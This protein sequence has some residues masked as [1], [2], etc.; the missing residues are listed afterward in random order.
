MRAV[1]LARATSDPASTSRPAT[2]GSRPASSHGLG[3][4]PA[5]ALLTSLRSASSILTG[6]VAEDSAAAAGTGGEGD[7]ANAH[8]A[9]DVAHKLS[10]AADDVREPSED[11]AA[12]TQ[13]HVHT[14][15][16]E[17]ISALV[18]AVAPSPAN[19]ATDDASVRLDGLLATLGSIR[20][21]LDTQLKQCGAAGEASEFTLPA[22]SAS[23]QLSDQDPVHDSDEAAE[24]TAEEEATEEEEAET[25]DHLM[26]C[27][28]AHIGSLF[29]AGSP[30]LR[31]M[32]IDRLA[33]HLQ[34]STTTVARGSTAG[35]PS[36]G[37]DEEDSRNA[38]HMAAEEAEA[39]AAA[40]ASAAGV[41][42]TS[43][44]GAP[45]EDLGSSPPRF[46]ARAAPLDP[47]EERPFGSSEDYWIS[48]GKG[49]PDRTL[50]TRE[51]AS[52][53]EQV[54]AC[55]LM[56]R[57]ALVDAEVRVVLSA[58]SLLDPD[59]PLLQRILPACGDGMAT[60]RALALLLAPLEHAMGMRSVRVSQGA[61]L[62]LYALV[63]HRAVEPKRLLPQLLRPLCIPSG[64][65]AINGGGVPALAGDAPASKA[66]LASSAKA[67]PPRLCCMR[68]QLV[69]RL[70]LGRAVLAGGPPLLQKALWPHSTRGLIP[71]ARALPLCADALRASD[72]EVRLA[73][74]ELLVHAHVLSPAE[75]EAWVQSQPNL[76]DDLHDE[77]EKQLQETSDKLRRARFHGN[78]EAR[79]LSRPG[80]SAG[81]GL[82]TLGNLMTRPDTAMGGCDAAVSLT[83]TLL[84][85]PSGDAPQIL[86]LE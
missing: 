6:R 60:R 81:T 79:S 83:R 21:S 9:V 28:P 74:V 43:P 69:Q 63:T 3:F 57:D 45:P 67:D 13:Q 4:T 73:A 84:E 54:L 44:E 46:W 62:A 24:A 76:R 85:E 47:S 55:C 10:Q 78:G 12:E 53:D 30:D 2:G 27:F 16:A 48:G 40:L 75:T 49:S 61:V 22:S 26:R 72:A 20:S 15:H 37:D 66:P 82:L 59:A 68:L 64:C 18:A 11:A 65:H 8:A 7:P 14:E 86:K 71:V 70:L 31:E 77:L 50:D 39:A 56:I 36:M 32:A 5:S 80:T 41:D 23:E 17:Q 35:L 29:G 52:A 42:S 19:S 33:S 25:V 1:R 34:A 51:A 58:L 38:L